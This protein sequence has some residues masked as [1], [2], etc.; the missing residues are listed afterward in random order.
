MLVIRILVL[1]LVCNNSTILIYMLVIQKPIVIFVIGF[2]I[3]MS[4]CNFSL[5]GFLLKGVSMI[6]FS[7][8][9][10]MLFIPLRVIAAL[11]SWTMFVTLVKTAIRAVVLTL[12]IRLF[13]FLRCLFIVRLKLLARNEACFVILIIITITF[14]AI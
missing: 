7:F 10:V 6:Y 11:I 3:R 14:M 2:F 4:T 5:N 9:A 8:R 12:T 13:V 1:V